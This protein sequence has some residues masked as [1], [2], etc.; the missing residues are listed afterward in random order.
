MKK[1]LLTVFILALVL[2]NFILTAILVFSI[3]PTMNKSN[4]LIT[5][6]CNLVDLELTDADVTAGSGDVAIENIEVYDIED[7]MT[8]NL[9]KGE[10]GKDHFALLSVSLSLNSKDDDYK[11]YNAD[12]LAEKESLIKS[13]I[14]SVVSGYTIEEVKDNTA[15]LQDDLLKH[16]QTMFDSKVITKVAFRDAVFQ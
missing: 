14:I 4:K 11:T 16:L 9:K 15:V 5:K 3:V 13:E 2:C 1:N 8:I 6:I 7:Q 10:D 12:T